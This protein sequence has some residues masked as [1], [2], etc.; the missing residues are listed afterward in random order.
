MWFKN[1]R[2]Y[3]LTQ[4]LVIDGQPLSKDNL[5][6]ALA[7]GEFVPCN[8][9]DVARYGWVSPISGH[10]HLVHAY[11]AYLMVCAKKQEKVLPASVINEAL[12]EKVAAITEAEGRPVGRKERQSMKDDVMID[13]LPRAFTRSSL[14]FAYIAPATDE[15]PFGYVV[16]NAASASKAEE[17]LSALRDAVGR[18]PVVPLV[19]KQLPHQAMTQWVNEASAPEKLL[20]GDECELAD[21]K[22]AGSVIRCKHQDL[23]SAEINSL[24]HAGMI[25]T[26]LGLQWREGVDFILDDQLAIKRLR[27]ADEIQEKVDGFEAQ[28]AAEQFGIEFSVMALELSALIRDLSIALGGVNIDSQSVEEIVAGATKNDAVYT[29]VD[30]VVL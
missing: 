14:Q 24:L 27:F 20:L 26:K 28:T 12:E 9:Q 15:S 22:E 2:V 7:A 10:D 4:A 8:S 11:Q 13:L 23:A 3:R 17:L 6:H 16:V 25:V 19:S 1:I 21:P 29:G 30:E 5:H 18:L